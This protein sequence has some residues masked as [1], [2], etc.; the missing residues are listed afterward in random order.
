MTA[1][2]PADPSLHPYA[3][4]WYDAVGEVHPHPTVAAADAT[5]DWALAF[6]ARIAADLRIPIDMVI[7]AQEALGVGEEMRHHP[8]TT[9]ASLVYWRVLAASG[10]STR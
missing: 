7:E 8:G 6:S 4:R 9:L 5:R 10:T 2:L 3:A 1:W